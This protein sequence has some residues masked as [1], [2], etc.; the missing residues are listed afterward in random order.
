MEIEKLHKEDFTDPLRGEPTV[1]F[2]KSGVVLFNKCAVKHLELKDKNGY[3]SV[4]FGHDLKYKSDFNVFK[5]TE[6]WQLRAN[7]GTAGGAIFNNVALTRHVIDVT[8]AMNNHAVGV[9]KPNSMVFRIARLPLDD[10]KNK[11]VYALLRKK[12]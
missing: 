5:D 11:D 4:S 12:E 1:R 2:T 10:D 7:K 3:A 9:E 8:W 6:G